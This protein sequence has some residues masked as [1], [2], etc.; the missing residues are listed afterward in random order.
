MM[1]ALFHSNKILN[2]NDFFSKEYS[3]I[4][5][6]CKLPKNLKYDT[7]RCLSMVTFSVGVIGEIM[8]NLNLNEVHG[9][10]DIII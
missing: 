9:H 7:D 10:G 8:Q 4:H 2:R 5:N 3:L 6:N 1:Q